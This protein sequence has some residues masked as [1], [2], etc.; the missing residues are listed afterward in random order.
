MAQMQVR[1]AQ[2][3]QDKQQS[4]AV[5]AS[6][7]SGAENIS[8]SES[9]IYSYQ[10]EKEALQGAV[11]SFFDDSANSLSAP[12]GR[13][14]SVS[15]ETARA[16]SPSKVPSCKPI[17]E[18][19]SLSVET[20]RAASPFKVP[21]TKPIQE[22]LSFSVETARTASPSKVPPSKSIEETQVAATGVKQRTY[23]D[24]AKTAV[25]SSPYQR[26]TPPPVSVKSDTQR[27]LELAL[28]E[29]RQILARLDHSM[30]TSISTEPSTDAANE[31]VIS[32]IFW[33]FWF[34]FENSSRLSFLFF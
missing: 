3:E 29:W 20:V 9:G 1:L 16:A 25:V 5:A 33:N 26:S 8:L 13:K 32:D 28:D 10:T 2:K 7:I 27:H 21:W 15:V 6:I 30:K 17:Q 4:S 22:T 11:S 12:D 24:V 18:T 19:H 23:A 31:M 14:T 34:V